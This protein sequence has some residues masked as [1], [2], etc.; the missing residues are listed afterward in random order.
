M[1]SVKRHGTVSS[2]RGFIKQSDNTI[3]KGRER[4][5]WKPEAALQWG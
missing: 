4:A 5:V 3:P 2:S 1:N